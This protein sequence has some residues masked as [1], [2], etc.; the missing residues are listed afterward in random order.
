MKKLIVVFLWFIAGVG[1]GQVSNP[2]IISVSI[3]PSG[4]CSA[5][6]PNQQVVSTGIQY[7]CQNVTGSIGTWAALAGGGGGSGTVTDFLAP[8]ASWPTWLVPT[9]TNPTTTPSLSVAAG[10]VPVANGGTGTASPGLVAGTNIANITGTWPN[11]TINASAQGIATPT[12][13]DL[14]ATTATSGTVTTLHRIVAAFGFGDSYV[15]GLGVVNQPRDGYFGRFIRD[16]KVPI[17]TNFGAQGTVTQQIGLSAFANVFFDPS[18]PIAYVNDGGINDSTDDTCGG[19]AGTNCV[20]NSQLAVE[21]YVAYESIPAAFRIFTSAATRT[22]TWA[23]DTT[24]VPLASNPTGVNFGTAEVATSSGATAA[25][26]IPSS[27][28]TKVGVTYAATTT[29]TGTFTITVDGVLQTNA[30]CNTGTTTFANTGCGGQTFFNGA[31]NSPFRQEFTVTAGTTHTVTITALSANPVRII[32]VDWIPPST[33]T[34]IN[35]VFFVSGATNTSAAGFTNNAVYNAAVGA[36]VGQLNTDGLPVFF[37]NIATNATTNNAAN[38]SASNTTSCAASVASGHPNLCGHEAIEQSIIATQVAGGYQVSSYNSSAN[39]VS[40]NGR[41]NSTLQINFGAPTAP[42]WAQVSHEMNLG[43]YVNPTMTFFD[44][45][46]QKFGIFGFIVDASTGAPWSGTNSTLVANTVGGVEFAG[47]DGSAIPGATHYTG[48][49][50]I[51]T[52][53]GNTSFN[54]VDSRKLGTL[55]SA[56]TIAPTAAIT[57]LTGSTS[58]ATITAPAN[59]STTYGGLLYF[60]TASGVTTTYTTGGNINNPTVVGLNGV[61]TGPAVVQAAWTGTAWTLSSTPALTGTRASGIATLAAGTVT[62]SSTAACTPGT[63]CVYKLTNCGLN[64]TIAVGVPSI[65]S[66][67][68]GTSFVINSLTAAAALAVDTS[69]VCWQ[70]N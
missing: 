25:F 15:Q 45:G 68:A 3:A 4:S 11:Q 51:N 34:N 32:A 39:T 33:T 8:S 28:S 52:S 61:V 29:G 43:Q 46:G 38:F 6:L 24:T 50:Y 7:S 14:L 70:I 64:S 57:T 10:T 13:G 63:A 26:S 54:G 66:V 65:G 60:L 20:M 23:A 44:A 27:A 40:S 30:G 53:N 36:I 69:S 58:I 49:G 2:S 41:I 12:T 9:V 56:S 17:Y 1:Y 48:I 37:D 22:G 55:A 47:Y 42:T 19:T 62:V 18:L 67:T 59:M 5:G 21:A 31:T 35:P 16:T